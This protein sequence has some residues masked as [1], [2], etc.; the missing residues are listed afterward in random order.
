VAAESAVALRRAFS[1]R[2]APVSA[3]LEE[4]ALQLE[5]RQDAPFGQAQQLVELGSR[6]RRALGRALHFDEPPRTGHHHVHVDLGAY[7]F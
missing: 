1:S 3:T 5:D 7:V 6:E 4:L 2:V